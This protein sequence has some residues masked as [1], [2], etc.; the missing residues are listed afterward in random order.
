[1]SQLSVAVA[2]PVAVGS[3]EP[4]HSTVAFAGQVITGSVVSCTVIV[5]EAELLVRLES[6]DDATIAVLE[7]LS[8][9][10]VPVTVTA[11]LAPEASVANEQLRLFPPVMEQLALSGLSV[12]VMPA[13]SVSE[14][15]TLVAATPEAALLAV[16][17]KLAVSPALIGVAFATLVM[18]TSVFAA[19]LKVTV[20]VPLAPKTRLQGLVVPLQV[21]ELAFVTPLHPPKVDP[22]LAVAKK[23]IV[24][25]LFEVVMLG[26]QV[27]VTVCEAAF[28]P[29]PP[30]E[31]GALTVPMFGVMVTDPLPVPAN[32]NTQL[33]ASVNVVCAVQPED[34]PLAPTIN[35]ILRS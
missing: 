9:F 21:E 29:V 14:I 32:V 15:V 13:G 18:E 5:A 30:H 11:W 7:R 16:I 12:Q 20:I 19:P 33:R 34:K 3:V 24:A 35:F 4:V 31:V 6:F 2:V 8:Q 1:V 22:T 26:K 23:V 25:P 27:L 28:V 17:V 10:A